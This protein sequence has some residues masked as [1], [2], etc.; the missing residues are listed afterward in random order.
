M[1]P[2]IDW[3]SGW[4]SIGGAVPNIQEI[5]ARGTFQRCSLTNKLFRVEV[6]CN[7]INCEKFLKIKPGA[8]KDLFRQLNQRYKG[9]QFRIVQD[10]IDNEWK[11]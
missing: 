1:A 2:S 4:H 3:S 11:E 7:G 6:E 5:K 9:Q 10:I 8:R